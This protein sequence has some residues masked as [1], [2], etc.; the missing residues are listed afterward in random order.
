MED[1]IKILYVFAALPVGGAEQVLVTEL[2]GLDKDLFSPMVCVI[3]EKGPVGEQIE[4]M[5]IPVIPLHRMKNN[6][7]DFGII[8]EI[9]E[10]ILQKKISIVHTHLYDG[11]KYGRIAARMA[12]VPGIVHTVHNIYIKR[13]TKHHLINRALAC[14]TDQII[15]V[16]EAVK[17][18]VVRYDRINPEKIEVIHNGIDPS[19]LD[20]PLEREE[21]RSKLG[22]KPGE[23]VIGV[24]AR[25]EEQKGHQ[26]LLEAL[27]L[28]PDLLPSLKVL[29]IGDG[30]LRSVL[31]EESK[32]RGLSTQVLFLGTRKPIIPILLALD[33]FLLPSLWEGF[34]MAILEAMAAGVPVIATRV[35]GA[36]EVITSGRDGF[37]IPPADAPSLAAAIEDALRHREKYQAMAQLG[38][39]KVRQSFSQEN[40]MELL[41]GLYLKTLLQK[42]LGR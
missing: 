26:Y 2:Q 27:S 37:L 14:I 9:K 7:F 22:I 4:Q 1:K 17:A 40:H 19:R 12:R 21:W 24:V 25:L 31:E 16:S 42:G 36:G 39:D 11:G 13:R 41:Q 23:F 28:R 6:R 5:G 10:I 32:R 33:L 35:G 20:Q 34:S 38:R 30:K 15:A 29:I 3:S 18:S 8:R